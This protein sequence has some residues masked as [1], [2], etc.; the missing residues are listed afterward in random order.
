MKAD[1]PGFHC[2]NCGICCK[3]YVGNLSATVGDVKRWMDEGE[4]GQKILDR[5]SAF[6]SE[7]DIWLLPKEC[8]EDM[9]ADLWFT[10]AGNEH[11]ACPWWHK[12]TGCR[13]HDTKP[14]MCADYPVSLKQ[15]LYDKCEGLP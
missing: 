1:I 3:K 7:L 4:A 2:N 15:V 9:V 12:N 6:A 13:I 10:P 5:V 8:D 14:K 11:Q